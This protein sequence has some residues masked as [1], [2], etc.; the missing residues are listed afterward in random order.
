VL[1]LS[2]DEKHILYSHI[3]PDNREDLY[4]V[5]VDGKRRQRLT[6]NG[7]GSQI[8]HALWSPD[9]QQIAF[10]MYRGLPR[11]FQSRLS[12]R[13]GCE[14]RRLRPET[15]HPLGRA[16]WVSARGHSLVARW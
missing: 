6:R 7:D 14:R 10:C 2:P 1:T 16:V 12:K 5:D 15:A 4:R 13:L 3:N 8:K 11:F 9:G